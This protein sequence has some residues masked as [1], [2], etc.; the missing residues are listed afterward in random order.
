MGINKGMDPQ[1]G[2]VRLVAAVASDK[3]QP[4]WR[5]ELKKNCTAC[6]III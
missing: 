6:K 2:G 4:K 3:K 1:P 5:A